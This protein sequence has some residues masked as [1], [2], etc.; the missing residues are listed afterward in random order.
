MPTAILVRQ[1]VYVPTPLY[2]SRSETFASA[3]V[4]FLDSTLAESII[5]MLNV[6]RSILEINVAGAVRRMLGPGQEV[7]IHLEFKRGELDFLTLQYVYEVSDIW[8]S[9][10][11]FIGKSIELTG[12]IDTGGAC[13]VPYINSISDIQR[14]IRIE[15]GLPADSKKPERIRHEKLVTG[16]SSGGIDIEGHK[17]SIPE[18]FGSNF[19]FGNGD[20]EFKLSG[21]DGNW[22]GFEGGSGGFEGD[23]GDHSEVGH[24]FM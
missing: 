1:P 6:Q 19:S 20:Y 13:R 4:D 3:A 14:D 11:G 8:I 17:G 15:F 23:T 7:S 22:G 24:G 2:K 5:P 21:I 12:E 18:N 16:Y 9:S 10:E